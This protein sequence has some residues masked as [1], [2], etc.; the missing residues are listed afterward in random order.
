[1]KFVND[2]TKVTITKV[3]DTD[4]KALSGAKL[5]VV[6]AKDK[7]VEEWT[8]DGT[9]HVI[10]GNLILG[11][12][13][14]LVE[15]EAPKGYKIADPITFV[16]QSD[17]TITVN[18]KPVSENKL[19]MVD[20]KLHFNV[21]KVELGNGKEVEGAHLVVIDKETGKTVDEWVSEKGKTHD[22]GPK[23]EAGKSYILRETVAPAGYKYATDIEFTVKKDGTIETNAK[24]TTDTDG[25]KVYLV[26]DDTTK[27]TITKVDA[28]G[29]Q[30]FEA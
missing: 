29:N 5:Q 9:P 3:N 30:L 25:N 16:M 24:T 6:D 8:T 22:F 18:A 4:R 14:K 2:S 11:E 10:I 15:K 27:V 7:V 23:L 28:L 20:A 19:T 21:N 1:M 17:G 12:T 13:Y 26:E